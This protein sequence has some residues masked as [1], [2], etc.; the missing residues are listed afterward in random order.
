MIFLIDF[1]TYFGVEENSEITGRM[2][3]VCHLKIDEISD[4]IAP[5]I[6]YEPN[7]TSNG[8]KC[9]Y[10]QSLNYCKKYS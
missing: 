7:K 8:C 3:A 6:L 1:K 10:H 4:I 9:F 5:K 2:L